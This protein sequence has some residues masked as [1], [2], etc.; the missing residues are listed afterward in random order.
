M[1]YDFVND[2]LASKSFCHFCALF[3]SLRTIFV[4]KL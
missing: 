3:A 4:A 1:D 2:Y